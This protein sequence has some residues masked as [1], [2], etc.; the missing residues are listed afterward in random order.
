MATEGQP[1][2]NT[3]SGLDNIPCKD[4]KGI[5]MQTYSSPDNYF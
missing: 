3:S 2:G 5:N 1:I 4:T